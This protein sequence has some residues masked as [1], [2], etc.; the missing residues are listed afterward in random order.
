MSVSP[1]NHSVTLDKLPL[2]ALRDA[3]GLNLNKQFFNDAKECDASVVEAV[4]PL[5][6]P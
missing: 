5:S 2:Q 4:S 6:S 3:S 1:G